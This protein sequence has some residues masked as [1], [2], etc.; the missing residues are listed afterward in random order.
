MRMLGREGS[1]GGGTILDRELL[2]STQISRVPLTEGLLLTLG[3][4]ST[5]TN[6]VKVTNYLLDLLSTK[7]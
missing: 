3:F 7:I 4:E 1:D 5:A 2:T 6:Q